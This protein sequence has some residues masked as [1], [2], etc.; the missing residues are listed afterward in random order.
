MTSAYTA[1]KPTTTLT[2][3]SGGFVRLMIAIR[4]QRN[5]QDAQNVQF[6]DTLLNSSL[7]ASAP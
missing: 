2:G 7:S 1:K 6:G 5:L 4:D 3:L